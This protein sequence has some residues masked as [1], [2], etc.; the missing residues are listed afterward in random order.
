MAAYH[1]ECWKQIADEIGQGGIQGEI[2][3]DLL[4]PLKEDIDR[5]LHAIGLDV[6]F[7][8]LTENEKGR[9]IFNF[10]W[11]DDKSTRPFESL[12]QGEQLLLLVAM[13]T[14]IIEKN[15]PPI[16]VLALD[17]VNHLDK[18]NVN[19]VIKGLNVAGAAMDNIILAGVVE[20]EETE[21]WTVWTLGM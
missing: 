12:S 14:T 4:N 10:G 15:N 9:E 6:E 8:F 7:F 13:M 1:V 5:K 19:R 18:N 3:K 16:K 17:N 2:V 21:G 20:P 11:A